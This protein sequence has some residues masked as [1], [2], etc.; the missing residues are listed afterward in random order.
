MGAAAHT[1]RRRV[2]A[3]PPPLQKPLPTPA[4]YPSETTATAQTAS[5][6]TNPV[7]KTALPLP[8]L[9]LS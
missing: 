8:K 2:V 4:V 6:L 3:T 7:R 5:P 9:H 1:K